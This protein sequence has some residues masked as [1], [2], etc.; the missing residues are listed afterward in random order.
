MC[1]CDVTIVQCFVGFS[2]KNCY[3]RSDPVQYLKH[4]YVQHIW[5]EVAFVVVNR[6]PE[7]PKAS[8]RVIYSSRSSYS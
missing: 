6:N 5:N 8:R 2:K 1:G 7:V 4:K 3:E